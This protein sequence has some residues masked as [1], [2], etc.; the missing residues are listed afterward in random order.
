MW[1]ELPNNFGPCCEDKRK[2]HFVSL[3][4][5]NLSR[6]ID[7]LKKKNIRER[8]SPTR[9]EP[10]R[11]K[12]RSWKQPRHRCSLQVCRE[13]SCCVEQQGRSSET[14]AE[15][16]ATEIRPQNPKQTPTTQD[17]R[18]VRFAN[19]EGFCP[20]HRRGVSTSG[21]IIPIQPSR[22]EPVIVMSERT[23]S[24]NRCVVFWRR[25]R[26][27]LQPLFRKGTP[28]T[29]K[30]GGG[31]CSFSVEEL[32]ARCGSWYGH[33]IREWSCEDEYCASQGPFWPRLGLWKGKGFRP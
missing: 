29:E 3:E 31:P 30:F 12:Q 11:E 15:L 17:V 14:G 16:H 25:Y 18:G 6:N 1:Q 22:N 5:N 4:L 13:H 33:G 10:L 28:S 24:Q 19:L 2:K 9:A 8:S 26:A 7:T 21:F 20:K 23:Q 32:F 27:C